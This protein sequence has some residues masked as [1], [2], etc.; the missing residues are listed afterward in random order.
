MRST[1]PLKA[2][3]SFGDLERTL[4]NVL[5]VESNPA[6]VRLLE[7][8]FS[9]WTG[10]RWHVIALDKYDSVLPVLIEHWIDAVVVD[11]DMPGEDG[12]ELVSLVHTNFP[13]LP[14]IALT[15]QPLA[16]LRDECLE[17]GALEYMR[18]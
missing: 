3:R 18:K 6:F 14:Q 9:R 2:A 7:E 8:V 5:V 13:A 4:K 15:E 1:N 16:A 17:T 11:M 12:T 10:Q